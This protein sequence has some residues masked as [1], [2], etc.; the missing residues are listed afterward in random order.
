MEVRVKC[1]GCGKEVTFARRYDEDL[2]AFTHTDTSFSP[3]YHIL[4]KNKIL[5]PYVLLK[6]ERR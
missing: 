1:P 3:P 6:I 4:Y 5:C 2:R